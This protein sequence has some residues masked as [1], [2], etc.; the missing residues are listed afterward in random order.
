[1]V[2]NFVN[3]VD[4]TNHGC[5]AIYK[6]TNGVWTTLTTS[7]TNEDWVCADLIKFDDWN[8]LKVTANG[9][10]LKF[11]IN[12]NLMWSKVV[13]GPVSGR[14]GVVTW[15]PYGF[16]EPLYV[17]WASAGAYVAASSSEKIAPNQFVLPGI[18][19]KKHK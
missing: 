18:S 15:R 12:N 11:Y 2:D 9:T 16:S 17:D 10:S 5:Y 7:L 6:I 13:T 3:E 1:M 4:N 8:D 14:L 19:S